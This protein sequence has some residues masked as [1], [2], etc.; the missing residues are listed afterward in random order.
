MECVDTPLGTKPGHSLPEYR[1]SVPEHITNG[2]RCVLGSTPEY[3]LVIGQETPLHRKPC[4]KWHDRGLIFDFVLRFSHFR[5]NS[6]KP[7]P[8]T[9]AIPHQKIKVRSGNLANRSEP[10][11]H[12]IF[13]CIFNDLLEL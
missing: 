12:G 1:H 9:C 6:G 2:D 8:K 7:E 5:Y 13:D 10:C 11:G 3:F 4:E